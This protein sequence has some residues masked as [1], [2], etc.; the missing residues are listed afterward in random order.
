MG[1]WKEYPKSQAMYEDAKSVFA[2]G[3]GSQVQSFSRP[4]PLYYD[5]RPWQQ[6]L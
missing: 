4:H 5:A 6:A 1:S 3:V 2:M